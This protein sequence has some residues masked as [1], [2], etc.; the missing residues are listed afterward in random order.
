[1]KKACSECGKDFQVYNTIT[2]ICPDCSR[3]I[4][5]RS[6]KPQEGRKSMAE[7]RNEWKW[8]KSPSKAK[9]LPEKKIKKDAWDWVSRYVRLSRS[10]D[11]VC[12]CYTCGALHGV[13]NCDAGHFIGRTHRATL[14]NLNNIRPQCLQC[15]RF[16][17]GQHAIFRDNLVKEIGLAEVEKLE[18]LARTIGDDSIAYHTAIR[19]EFKQKVKDLQEKIGVKYW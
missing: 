10:R 14:Y 17:Q 16:K 18:A 1:M 4:L 11:G 13:K 19:D 12:R 15:N 3:K 7:R 5:M 6:K 8:G 9:T 2:K